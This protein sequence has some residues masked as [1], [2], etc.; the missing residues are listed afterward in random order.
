MMEREHFSLCCRL[1]SRT[2]FRT[3]LPIPTVDLEV[4]NT[5]YVKSSASFPW[6]PPFSHRYS[7]F[8]SKSQR[9]LE[10]TVTGVLR[11]TLFQVEWSRSKKGEGSQVKQ[12]WAGFYSVAA[13][14]LMFHG[15]R[16]SKDRADIYVHNLQLFWM[17][18]G[19]L[20]DPEKYSSSLRMNWV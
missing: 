10:A 19:Q 8:N 12:R 13:L 9:Q 5:V 3:L 15:T 20:S 11:P 14:F 7:C 17:M 2:Q 18:Q 1:G 4:S 16:V 6:N